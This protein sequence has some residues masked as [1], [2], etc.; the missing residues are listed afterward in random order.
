MAVAVDGQAAEA[1]LAVAVE[2]L[3]DSV[4]EVPEAVVPPE[5]GNF[6]TC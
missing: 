1:G 6:F 5:A 4:V 2:D 3:V